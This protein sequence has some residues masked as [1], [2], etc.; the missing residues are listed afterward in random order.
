MRAFLLLT[1][2]LAVPAGAETLVLE[3]ATVTEWK[4][5]YGTVEARETVPARARIGGIVQVLSV[6]EGDMIAAGQEIALVH[7][8]KIAFQ[9]AALDAQIEALKAQLET[10]RS[11]LERGQTLVERGVV[12]VQ[13]LDQLR[14]N[15]DVINGQ[16]SGPR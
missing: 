5:V 7:D 3:P 11:D 1:S 6:S 8:D 14:T 12:T 4:S 13:R 2:L 9:I 10:A 15:V 16:I